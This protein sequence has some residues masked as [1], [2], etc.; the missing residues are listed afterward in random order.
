[1]KWLAVAFSISAAICAFL[2]GN[3]VQANTV[4]DV[5]QSDFQID[6]WITGLVTAS[7]VAAVILGGIKRIGKV[8]SRLVPFMGV[9]YVAGA[10]VILLLNYEDIIPSFSTIISY[11]FNPKAEALG[12]GTGT[13][14]LTLSY[15]VQL[16]IISHEAGQGSAPIADS[17]AKTD[18]PV[19]EG[20]VALLEHFIDTLIICTMTG[21]VIVSTGAWDMHHKTAIKPANE[22]FSYAITNGN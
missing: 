16:G 20:V 18:E 4:S 1:W 10:L 8:T 11:A 22:S 7:L 12:V 13:F 6:P 19:R 14:M 21:L 15:G 2:T 3:A 9:L 17:A 5:M